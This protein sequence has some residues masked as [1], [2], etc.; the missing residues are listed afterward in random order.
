MLRQCA[1]AASTRRAVAIELV[2]RPST[3]AA[4]GRVGVDQDLMIS[5]HDGVLAFAVWSAIDV[6]Q[7][8]A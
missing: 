4:P 1:E 6:H 8:N 2:G 3:T 5:S 7:E